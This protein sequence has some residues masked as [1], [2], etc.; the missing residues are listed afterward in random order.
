MSK[1]LQNESLDTKQYSYTSETECEFMM[2]LNI[3]TR[4]SISILTAL[5][6][7]IKTWQV[8]L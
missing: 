6:I 2:L 8:K 4:I 5:Y 7:K 1:Y 3:S